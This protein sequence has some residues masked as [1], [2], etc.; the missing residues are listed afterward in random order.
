MVVV[1]TEDQNEYLNNKFLLGDN[2]LMPLGCQYISG[3]WICDDKPA[4]SWY[5]LNETENDG[6]WSKCS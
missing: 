3:R 5:W 4:E 6:Y 1:E 2:K